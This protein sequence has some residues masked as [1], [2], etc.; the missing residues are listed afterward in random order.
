M[1]QTQDS[2]VTALRAAV[3]AARAAPSIHNTQP[4]RWRISDGRTLDLYADRSRQL[5]V[6][7]PDGRLLT[8]SCGAALHH[9]RLALTAAGWRIDVRRLPDQ[10][11]P[12]LLATITVTG[13]GESDEHARVLL[14][15]ASRRRTDR[16]PITDRPVD[17]AALDAIVAAVTAEDTRLYLL[18]RDQVVELAAAMAAAERTEVTEEAHRDEIARWVG[19]ERRD[20]TGIPAGAVPRHA[21]QTQVPG[22]YFGP[23]G[24]LPVDEGHDLA[25]VYGILHGDSDTPLAWVRAGE[26][27]SAGWLTATARDL[28]L[29]PISAVVEVVAARMA[30]RR[31]LSGL[32][33]PYLAVRIGYPDPDAPAPPA[34]PRLTADQII[35]S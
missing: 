21:P 3:E 23:P 25:A 17:Q 35:E 1:T 20:A 16:R 6:E 26:A 32:G 9:A 18:R 24:T 11:Q 5:E 33:Y 30:L 31:L 4:W 34:T 13:R 14:D 27:L 28:S 7:D 29:L 10:N 2:E 19:G 15:A 22:R 12:D 8:E